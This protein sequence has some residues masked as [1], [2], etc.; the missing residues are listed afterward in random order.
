MLLYS[1]VSTIVCLFCSFS[2]GIVCASSDDSLVSSNLSYNLKN[3]LYQGIAVTTNKMKSLCRR[4]TRWTF[5]TSVFSVRTIINTPTSKLAFI[6]VILKPSTVDVVH[7]NLCT[8]RGTSKGSSWQT[9]RPF[10]KNIKNWNYIFN[11]LTKT[12]LKWYY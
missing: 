11:L 4:T 2:V 3:P 8:G 9:S 7:P 10:S 5:D 6:Y 12:T 1:V